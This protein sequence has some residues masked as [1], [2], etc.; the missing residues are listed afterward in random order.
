[1]FLN[2]LTSHFKSYY[3]STANWIDLIYLGYIPH[4]TLMCICYIYSRCESFRPFGHC[5]ELMFIQSPIVSYNSFHSNCGDKNL[6]S[7][8][9]NARIWRMLWSMCNISHFSNNL[10]SNVPKTQKIGTHHLSFLLHEG[11]KWQFLL[12]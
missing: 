2:G 3:F 4:D 1:M 12:R 5:F 10:K 6:T 11:K 9:L 8:A 7:Q